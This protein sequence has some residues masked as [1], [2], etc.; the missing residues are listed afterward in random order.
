MSAFGTTVARSL[1]HMGDAVLSGLAIAALKAIRLINPDTVSNIGGWV[2]RRVGPLLREHRI[3]RDNLRAAFP[4]KS[5][6]E[7][8]R[9]LQGVW[10]N[11][12]R[13]GAEFAHIDKLWDWDPARPT[14]GRIMDLS[15]PFAI[16]RRSIATG[17]PM[18]CFAAHLANWEMPAV[19]CHKLGIKSAV[20]YRRPNLSAVADA[21]VD[22]RTGCM[23]TL[24]PAG[25][26]AP[27]KLAEAM[28]D[29]SQIG[30]LVDQY[31]VRGVPV[32]FFGRTTM[33]NPLLAR[34]ARQHECVIHG[35]RAIRHPGNRFEITVTEP[36]PPVRDAEGQ[37]D[38][39]GTMQAI[40]DVVESWVREH[41]EQWLWLHRRWRDE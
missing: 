5:G 26:S 11:L 31:Y 2:M 3:G 23:G 6:A 39:Q 38:V 18:L 4:E 34:L 30:L 24:V 21:V 14:T 29:K 27:L 36:I 20:L 25:L 19:V 9:I 10:E 16:A 8:E 13:V 22:I 28:Q 1:K 40:T 35:I 7:I 32:T 33:A 41:P 12:G 15:V 37:I 17:K